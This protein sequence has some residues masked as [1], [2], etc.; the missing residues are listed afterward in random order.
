MIIRGLLGVDLQQDVVRTVDRALDCHKAV[1]DLLEGV[2]EADH[3]RSLSLFEGVVLG[4]LHEGHDGVV[5]QFYFLLFSQVRVPD[6]E[7]VAGDPVNG[8]LGRTVG[9]FGLEAKDVPASGNVQEVGFSFVVA[10]QVL[11]L[12]DLEA[13]LDVVLGARG[14]KV[15]V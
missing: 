10:S 9:E 6:V 13:R 12:V 1:A 7:A 14:G 11:D 3:L 15:G 2:A 5:Q 4:L 8:V